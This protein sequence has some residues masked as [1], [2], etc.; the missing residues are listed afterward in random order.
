MDEIGK[1]VKGLEAVRFKLSDS[2]RL[3]SQGLLTAANLTA[4]SPF[5]EY[6][7]TSSINTVAIT[8]SVSA[9]ATAALLLAA[10]LGLGLARGA[11]RRQSQG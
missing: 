8:S 11:R 9:G 1:R 10:L 4:S 6:W 3:R 5:T 7:L 2:N